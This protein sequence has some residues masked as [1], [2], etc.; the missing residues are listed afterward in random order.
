MYASPIAITGHRFRLF[1]RRRW[2]ACGGE[3]AVGIPTIPSQVVP[4]ITR[5]SRV[6]VS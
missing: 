3:D 5:W 1:A 4:V 2:G 6:E